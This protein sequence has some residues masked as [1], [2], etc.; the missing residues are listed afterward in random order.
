MEEM[1]SGLKLVQELA[2][3][4]QDPPSRY[5][6]SEENYPV[7]ASLPP[8]LI[9]IID[10][11]RLSISNGEDESAKL[12]SAANSWGLFLVSSK[13]KKIILCPL[14]IHLLYIT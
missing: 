13:K 7:G 14:E 11:S 6:L 3:K 4:G 10:L 12:L 5:V 1:N 2:M 9:P 8:S